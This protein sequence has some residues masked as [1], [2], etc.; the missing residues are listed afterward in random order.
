M[1]LEP[2][3]M[4]KTGILKKWKKTESASR[5]SRWW[6]AG[7]AGSL[8]K[9]LHVM[10]KPVQTTPN[11]T[12]LQCFRT[13][14]ITFAWIEIWSWKVQTRIFSWIEICEIEECNA[15]ILMVE[16]RVPAE[17]LNGCTIENNK[18]REALSMTFF[19]CT[20]SH[21]LLFIGRIELNFRYSCIS[22]QGLEES[23]GYTA[24]CG[25]FYSKNG[26]FEGKWEIRGHPFVVSE[27]QSKVVSIRHDCYVI[28]F[29]PR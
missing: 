23:E 17:T 15:L 1:H 11:E 6:F 14:F 20:F 28:L 24:E 4:A 18:W 16:K 2:D 21:S 10:N 19:A 13:W 8:S 29:G 3:F 22:G 9:G 25:T 5:P 26:R 12:I 27:F 7:F